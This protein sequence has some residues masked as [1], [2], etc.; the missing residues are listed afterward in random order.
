MSLISW[1]RSP[2]AGILEPRRLEAVTFHRFPI[3]LPRSDGTG[4]HDLRFFNV[5]F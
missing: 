3:Y 2:S 5:E 4:C 1:L